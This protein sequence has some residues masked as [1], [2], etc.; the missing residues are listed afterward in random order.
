MTSEEFQPVPQILM[1]LTPTEQEKLYNQFMAIVRGLDGTDAVTLTK[2]VMGRVDLKEKLINMVAG[3]LT[4]E[5]K[6]KV[7]YGY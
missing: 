4:E 2:L 1:E 7:Q 5:L 6:A 3:F